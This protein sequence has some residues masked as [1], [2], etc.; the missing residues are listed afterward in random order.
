MKISMIVAYGHDWKIGINNQMP[1]HI[2]A[3]FANFKKLTTGHHLLMGRKTFESI[4]K[5]LPDR[6]S[7]ILSRTG[8]SHAGV[9]SFDTP[10]KAFDFALSNGETEL[11]VI[12]GA[13]IYNTLFGYIDTM[14]LSVVDYDGEADAYL[15]P[16]DFSK[17]KLLKEEQHEALKNPDGTQKSPA[18]NFKI[19]EKML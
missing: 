13:N 7:L 19:W 5:P 10:Q 8:F 4:G 16:I 3:D 2:S 6:T 15:N 17:W 9:H 14:Y 18:W 12:G 1:W 11:F